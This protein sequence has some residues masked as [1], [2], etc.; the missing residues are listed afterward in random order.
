MRP[1][2]LRR[3]GRRVVVLALAGLLLLPV[4]AGAVEEPT[5]GATS[6]ATP[7][8]TPGPTIG[9][10]PGPTIGAT[11][12]AAP[13]PEQEPAT[14]PAPAASPVGDQPRPEFAP[15]GSATPT[16]PTV[17]GVDALNP[18]NPYA[19]PSFGVGGPPA[20][21]VVGSGADAL[22]KAPNL[23]G[24]SQPTLLE[25]YGA[26]GH[27][28]DTQTGFGSGA[29][30]ALNAMAG[31]LFAIATWLAQIVIATFQWAFSIEI[32]SFVGEAVSAIVGGLQGVVYEP[33]I[34]VAVVL[35]GL[36]MTW[37]GLVRRRGNIA[38]EQMG[39]TVFA[40]TAAAL[41][42]LSPAA[43]VNGANQ[44]STGLSRAALT[45]VSVADPMTGP[46][47]GVTVQ[48]TYEGGAADDQLR[49]AADRFWRVFVHQPWLVLQFGDL[50]TGATFGERLL[51]A[52]TI[53]ADE[54]EAT[55]GD[56]E[57]L[58]ALTT[59]K[60][61]TYL[62]L[63]E[64]ILASPQ[65]AEW[66]RG[67]R[68]VERLGVATLALAGV[69]VGG[70]LLVLVAAAVLLAQTGFLLLV[71][72]GPFALLLGVHPGV[73]RVIALRWAGLLAGLLLKRVLLGTLL[74]VILVVNGVL[75]DAAYSL[76]WLVVMGLQTLVVAAVVVYRKPFTRLLG[77]T[78]MPVLA[79]RVRP[80]VEGA[81][82]E[83]SP[84]GPAPDIRTRVA[85]G[86][87]PP[88]R[89]AVRRSDRTVAPRPELE[90]LPLAEP[91][92]ALPRW[93]RGRRRGRS[94][95]SPPRIATGPSVADLVAAAERRRPNGSG[96]AGSGHTGSGDGNQSTAGP[97]RD[98]QPDRLPDPLGQ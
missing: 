51:A 46:D 98:A 36:S 87:L 79:G 41:F 43:L 7:G 37:S 39:W 21:V 6:G 8:A 53:T 32:F 75:L 22:I 27:S 23:R 11:P 66:F 5:P 76:G 19:V 90:P 1:R 84:A 67:R 88:L 61:E 52:K 34:I 29:D 15:G 97:G 64:E 44:V 40:L 30:Q 42:F 82:A 93:V 24:D 17:P 92:A 12:D 31:G 4:G 33:F 13:T 55:D 96:H 45:A 68:A 38:A 60:R 69:A 57:A 26:Q 72:L 70:L 47:D 49:I 86:T 2:P 18:Y 58:A 83:A 56:P 65:A 71:L 10:T 85:S 50:D 3:H 63:Q 95:P 48:A 20:P 81:V 54:L 59:T 91:G 9:A 78:T 89:R 94:A 62:A 28:L 73:G 25:R 80:A 77:P 16:T 14:T 74:G 35:A